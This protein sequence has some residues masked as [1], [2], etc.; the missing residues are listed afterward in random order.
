MAVTQ[1]LRIPNVANTISRSSTNGISTTTRVLVVVV[2]PTTSGVVTHAPGALS[3]TVEKR[4]HEI[5]R[6]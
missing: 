5:E 3:R 6:I 1:W 2:A 4:L